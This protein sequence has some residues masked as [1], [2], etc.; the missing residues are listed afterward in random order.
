MYRPPAGAAGGG[1]AVVGAAS[2]LYPT[3]DV[4]AAKCDAIMDSSTDFSTNMRPSFLEQD[5]AKK[6]S[7]RGHLE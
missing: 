5:A 4:A 7:A 1:A 6:V 2:G 3:D